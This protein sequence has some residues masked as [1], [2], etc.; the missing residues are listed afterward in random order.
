MNLPDQ[1]PHATEKWLLQIA[2]FRLW[3]SLVGAGSAFPM[4]PWADAYVVR[5]CLEHKNIPN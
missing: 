4:D 1:W 3:K 5:P 2:D